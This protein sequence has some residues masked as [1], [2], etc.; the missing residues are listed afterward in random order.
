MAK[1]RLYRRLSLKLLAMLLLAAMAGVAVGL[2]LQVLGD[3]L[4]SVVYCSEQR[5]AQR[6]LA[7]VTSFRSYVLEEGVSSTDVEKIGAWNW[8]HPFI[9]LTIAANGSVLN[10]DRWGAELVGSDS[11]LV[12][13]AGNGESE[14]DAYPVNF[15]DGAYAVQI[16]DFSQS[17]LFALVNWGAVGAGGMLFL[18]LMLL[19]N[20]RVTSAISRLARQVR[21]VSK[22]N[23]TLEITPP[24][25]DE[26]GDLAEDVDAMRLSIIDKLQREETAWRANAELIT[27][28]SHDV[29]TPL[30]TLMGYLDILGESENLT[31]AQQQ[32]YLEVCR[33]KAEK[34]RELT[35]ELF[36]YFLVFGKPEP[37]LHMESFDAATLLDQV[38]GEQTADL[39]GRG[40]QVQTLRFQESFPIQVD[41][42]HLRRIFDNLF[43]NVLKY[44]DPAQPVTVSAAWEAGELHV[45]ISNYILAQAGLVES[46][47]IGL[48]TCEK[49][50]TS[51]NGRFSRHQRGDIFTA[52][53]ILPV[54]QRIA[55]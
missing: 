52:E 28:I 14:Y 9:R 35:N 30:T 12:I 47:K 6:L 20:S 40:Y 23:L 55:T 33:R 32:Q 26:I 11:G 4:V 10:S 49:L 7:T 44:A 50:L 5:Q 3:Y 41:V 16:Q 53:V 38:L 39:L 19:Y 13:R 43:S 45:R 8:D 21:Q 36:S 15:T 37:E 24:S 2:T 42:Q 18:A 54:E 34:L 46:T 27:A 29:R 48:Q 31:P 22:G 25:R 51:M 1:G 17:Q